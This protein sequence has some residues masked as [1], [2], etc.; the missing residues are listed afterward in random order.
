[1]TTKERFK[2]LDE[3][4]QRALEWAGVGRRESQLVAGGDL[5]AAMT[6]ASAHGCGA[7]GRSAD[8]EWAFKRTG[9]MR[10]RVAVRGEGSATDLA[11]VNMGWAKSDLL[12]ADGTAYV[13]RYSGF[14]HPKLTVLDSRGEPVMSLV[15]RGVAR[16]R[17][18]ITVER[19]GD[20]NA[21]MLA[22]LA[23]YLL[24]LSSQDDGGGAVVATLVASGAI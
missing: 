7:T 24:L 4:D 19:P 2:R 1:M 21:S 8:G 22:V 10:P 23:W 3:A 17:A 15:P 5:V 16:R 13:L 18:H 20:P 14:L 9:L 11:V 12:L 6:W